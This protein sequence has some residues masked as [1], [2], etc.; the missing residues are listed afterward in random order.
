VIGECIWDKTYS[1]LT[2][3]AAELCGHV[4]HHKYVYVIDSN[5]SIIDCY[6]AISRHFATNIFQTSIIIIFDLLF[7]RLI[8]L[9]GILVCLLFNLVHTTV[10]FALQFV[11]FRSFIFWK[12]NHKGIYLQYV[13][14]LHSGLS[15]LELLE[16]V[17]ISLPTH[18]WLQVVLAMFVRTGWSVNG[19]RPKLTPYISETSLPI[20]TKLNAIHYVRETP[21]RPELIISRSKWPRPQRV[22]LQVL[23]SFFIVFVSCHRAQLGRVWRSIVKQRSLVLT[24]CLLGN[25]TLTKSSNW[26][27]FPEKS[28]NSVGNRDFQLKQNH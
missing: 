15:R 11:H 28:Q 2:R 8:S 19:K 21:Q 4:A 7:H 9:M 14:V 18:H 27:I 24:K 5:S 26:F 12:L 25:P 23:C 3:Y 13:V 1:E 17:L 10:E 16:T 20:K 6:A 22:N